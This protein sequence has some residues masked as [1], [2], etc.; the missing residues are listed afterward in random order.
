MN[1]KFY[2]TS[3]IYYV[4]DIPHIGHAY[5]TII[6]DTLARFAKL[7]G[8]EVYFLTGT[9][10]H[11]QKIEQSAQKKGRSPKEYVDEISQKFKDLWDSFGISY[12]HFIR[13][14]DS[15]HLT[16]AQAA[17]LKM[18]EKGDIYKG[19]YEGHYCVSCESFFT[20][21]QLKDDKYCP[22]CGKETTILEEESYFFRLSAY[23]DKLLRFYEEHSD[24]ILPRFRRNEVIN[25][26]QSGLE[27]LSITRTTF[28]WGIK[29]PKALL[30]KDPKNEKHVMYV[31]LDALINYLS[32]LGFCN[33]LEDRMDFWAADYHI[34]GKDILRFHA[35]YWP[36]FLM[37]LDL[38]LPRHIA[39]HG[40][41]TKDG[42][43]MSKSIG[44]VVNPKEVVEAYGLD[45]FRYFVLREVPFGQ[46]GDFSQKALIER[47]NAD[48]GNDLGNLLNRLLGMSAKYF[49]NQLEVDCVQLQA[50]YNAEFTQI[51]KVLTGLEDS[52]NVVQIHRY[53]EELW[54][55]FSLG[56]GIIAKKEPWR[57][58]KENKKEEVAELLVFIANLLIKSALCLSPCMPK[59][60]ESILKVFGLEVDSKNYQ[61]F[62][63]QGELLGTM[64]LSAI[65]VLF[66]KIESALL[67]DTPKQEEKPKHLLQDSS[68]VPALEIANPISK[69]DF[70]KIEIKVGTVISAEELP[71]SEKLL[72]LR[73][74]L[75]EA[76][77][78]QILAGI[79]AHYDTQSLIGKQVC[80]LANLKPAKLMGQ[81]SEGMILATK[82]EEGLTLIVP[83]NSKKNGSPIS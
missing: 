13:T 48:L 76:R 60:A 6:V 73:V 16:T 52:M 82:D 21:F 43:K 61:R 78:R 67:E 37:S 75:G 46:D 77:A 57:L 5:T 45:C 41:W 71:K 42:A 27:D 17:F 59:S 26:V 64:H 66:P 22:D 53:L 1:S 58:I 8:K 56:N 50:H 70:A 62:V 12:D 28:D 33:D 25:F 80:V 15:Y 38:P 4:N 49:D 79:K 11:G 39:A 9:D 63:V 18:F 3:P 47:I 65:G 81:I 34:V 31:W 51:S 10:E 54:T 14:T 74:D 83:Q 69:E 24:F 40:W 29:L 7:K 35:I 30:D 72:K 32:A 36:A 44:N 20:K 68:S 55:L 2:I 19:K 23:G